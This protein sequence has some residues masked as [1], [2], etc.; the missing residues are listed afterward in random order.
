MCICCEKK[1]AA[2]S[3]QTITDLLHRQLR[4][5]QDRPPDPLPR[6]PLH[7]RPHPHTRRSRSHH[8]N[9]LLRPHALHRLPPPTPPPRPLSPRHLRPRWRQRRPALARRLPARAAL[10]AW[11][12]RRRRGQHADAVHGGAVKTRGEFESGVCALVSRARDGHAE[13]AAGGALE[14]GYADVDG[15]GGAAAVEAVWEGKRGCRRE[16]AVCGDGW[17]VLPRVKGEGK[18][19]EGWKWGVPCAG[20]FE[21]DGGGAGGGENEEGGRGREAICSYDGCVRCGEVK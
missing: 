17:E 3:L 14:L 18:R 10:L 11:Q 8:L 2:L 4:P 20:R 1:S 21:C 5:D 13:S 19:W 15:V 6:L 7:R 16:G 12:R 9:P